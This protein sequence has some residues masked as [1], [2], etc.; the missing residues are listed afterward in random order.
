LLGAPRSVLAATAG[1]SRAAIHSYHI[2]A[3]IARSL[4]H[5]FGLTVL[6]FFPTH[7]HVEN[8]SHNAAA[9]ISAYLIELLERLSKDTFNVLTKGDIPAAVAHYAEAR[10]TV[11]RLTAQLTEVQKHVDNLSYQAL[12][13]MF[14]NANVTSIKIDGVGRATVNDHWSASILN[15]EAGFDWLRKTGNEGLIIET[16][17]AQTLGA[18]AKEEV[19]AKRPLPDDIFKVTARPYISIEK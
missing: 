15:R 6:F 2:C 4:F 11:K 5:F 8:N 3:A 19:K 1:K 12:P 18:F 14:A 7:Y 17:N 9:L 13:T 16:V 10:A